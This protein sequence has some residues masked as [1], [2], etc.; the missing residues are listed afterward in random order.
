MATAVDFAVK[1]YDSKDALMRFLGT[2]DPMEITLRRLAAYMY[3]SRSGDRTGALH[4]LGVAPP[5]SKTDVAPS[6]LKKVPKTAQE[7]FK[8]SL[9]RA[10]R[11]NN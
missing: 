2:S 11:R 4:L 7:G 10:R 8:R 3:E 5:G 6:W 1:D 9:R